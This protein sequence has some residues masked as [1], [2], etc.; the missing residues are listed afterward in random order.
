M[1]KRLLLIERQGK[2]IQGTLGF[3]GALLTDRVSVF[4][5]RGKESALWTPDTFREKFG[6]APAQYADFKSLTD[7][8]ADNIK[9]AGGTRACR[10]NK[11]ALRKGICYL[12][13]EEA[14]DEL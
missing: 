3:V 8:T 7:D 1:D 13:Y 12:K 5:Y 11:E 6:I 14:A 4:R 9:G 10:R 2:P